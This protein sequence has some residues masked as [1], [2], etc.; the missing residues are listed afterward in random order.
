MVNLALFAIVVA[1]MFCFTNFAYAQQG[2]NP[3]SR[4][5]I[6]GSVTRP[7]D[8]PPSKLRSK[9]EL[10]QGGPRARA[11]DHLKAFHFT[12]MD[13]DSLDADE[14]GSILYTDHFQLDQTALQTPSE[15]L[16]AQAAVPVSPF[17][18]SLVFHSRPGAP[19][20]LYLNFSGENL[21]NTAWNSSVGR[22][23][24]P[25]LAFSLDADNSTFSDSEQAAIKRIWQR[26]SE[27]YAPFN[28]DVTTE[29]PATFGSRTAHALITRSTDA[30]GAANPSS[31]A[32]GVGY[33]NV[34]GSTSYTRNRPVW[35]YY[36]N[37]AN[38]DSYVAEAASHEI[39]HNMG[40]SHDGTTAGREYYGGHGS[41]ETSW[42]PLMGTGYGRNVSQWSKGDYYQANNTQD[43]LAIIA[44]KL[45]YRTDDHGDT[46][47]NATP[48]VITA[49]T[50]IS[51]T[52][53]ES[54]LTNLN[55]A[56]K[57]VLEQNT[58]VDVF[59]CTAGAGTI[60]LAVAP[61]VTPSGTRGGNLD[62]FIELRDAS[63]NLI[64]TENS[65]T[66]TG[67][68]IQTA[69]ASGV[70]YLYVR[71]SG[72]GNPLS[73]TPTG[74]TS[75]GSIGQYFISGFIPPTNSSVSLVRLTTTVNNTNWGSVTPSGGNFTAGATL[76]LLATPA[77]YY[78]FV[79]W[80][81]GATGTADP[82]P[83]TLQNNLTVTALFAE[84]FTTNHPTPLWW[85][86]SFGYKTNFETA[87]VSIGANGLPLWQSY[88]AGLNPTLAS[89]QLKLSISRPPNSTATVL[90]W[91]TTAGHLYTL[92]SNTNLS[93]NFVRVAGAS[94]LSSSITSFTDT[95]KASP[96]FYRLETSAQ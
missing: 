40:L 75:Y 7:E 36:N 28:I 86:A 48:L 14:E 85:L 82:L 44:A 30:D 3:R 89:S 71:N 83:I 78:R 45:T 18:S 54:D 27:D 60:R 72:S 87:V 51:S 59:S 84:M 5:F 16:I 43:D 29:R 81:N 46:P 12:E 79:G 39:G 2:Q 17:P 34:F 50:N 90:K 22:T 13:L 53:P 80:T 66:A 41:G 73:S 96:T 69:V 93:G 35:I 33:V 19:N 21:T 61:W 6:P 70:Y 58:D 25:A 38:N 42:G 68:A 92:W 64:P 26:V 32:G 65:D 31:T 15:P 4:Q 10:L 8:L 20:V 67:A 52:T 56:N 76:Q 47:Q 1:A 55:P 91:T 77:L 11:L 94:N 9:L 63:G 74:Y 95:P 57:G 23:L 37:L 49:G 62:L 88:T 24:I